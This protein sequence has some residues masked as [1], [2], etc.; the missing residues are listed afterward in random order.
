MEKINEGYLSGNHLDFDN[1]EREV[2]LIAL[3]NHLQFCSCY[4]DLDD[5]ELLCRKLLRKLGCN[6][7]LISGE[8]DVEL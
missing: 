8:V 5:H 3:T 7:V 4:E 1:D 6:H 2:L